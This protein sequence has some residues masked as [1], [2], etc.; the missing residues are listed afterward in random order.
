[1]TNA[2]EGKR[3][4]VLGMAR[5]G[6]SAALTLK[7]LGAKVFVS[8]TKPIESLKQE[9]AELQKMSIE[10]ENGIHSPRVLE[11]DAI[12]LSPGIPQTIPILQKAKEQKIPILGEIELAYQIHPYSWIA[13]TGSNGKSTT[14]ALM[15]EMIQKSGRTGRVVGNIGMAATR[16]LLRFPVDGILV[17][18]LSSF[19][20]ETIDTFKPAVA[21]V[22]NLTPNHLDRYPGEQAYYDAKKR[23]LKNMG[24]EDIFVYNYDDLRLRSWALEVK[25]KIR[26]LAFSMKKLEQ[27][28]GAWLDNDHIAY[29]LDGKTHRL[30]KVAESGI[31]GPHNTANQ[32]AA[33]LMAKSCGVEDSCLVEILR[34]FKGLEHRMEFVR[35]RNNVKYYNDSKAT[36]IESMQVALNSFSEPVLLLAGGRDK[37]SA[38]KKMNAVIKKHCKGVVLYGESAEKMQKA[39]GRVVTVMR[40]S[41]LMDAVKKASSLAEPG[42]AVLLSPACASFDMFKDFEDR[43]K[44]FKKLVM[45]L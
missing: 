34:D 28:D 5:S 42:E 44:T 43:G 36:T 37:G 35:E 38:F 9:L 4:S 11:A 33:A 29:R 14:T 12:V 13:I 39:W 8:D 17:A 1:M 23:I 16:E 32:M 2:F 22:L 20:L 27:N 3:V 10:T 7:E 26:T 30:F 21:T 25:N 45:D 18:E 41:D 15:G 40:A 19:Q 6:L 24:S 31:R